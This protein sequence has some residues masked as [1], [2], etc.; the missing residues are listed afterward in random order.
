[1]NIPK[2]VFIDHE[3]ARYLFDNKWFPFGLIATFCL[4]YIN[5]LSDFST[6]KTFMKNQK[7]HYGFS[8]V[9]SK[10]G[11]DFSDQEIKEKFELEHKAYEYFKPCISDN[12]VSP[13]NIKLWYL[14]VLRVELEKNYPGELSDQEQEW[15]EQE[16][17][18]TENNYKDISD[19]KALVSGLVNHAFEQP[20]V[21][22]NNEYI[23]VE[24]QVTSNLTYLFYDDLYRLLY[25]HK[26]IKPQS[27]INCNSLFPAKNSKE[28][29]CLCCRNDIYK[30]NYSKVK[31][32]PAKRLH[33]NIL[34]YYNVVIHEKGTSETV[35]KFRNESNYYSAIVQG[36]KPKTRKL[37]NY[38][39]IK[40]ESEY[41]SWLENFYQE[42]K[43]N[44]TN[45]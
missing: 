6:Y 25:N 32:N 40:T 19:F 41:I 10:S 44:H 37:K 17:L 8:L 11:T 14:F 1:M 13:E 23:L 20:L 33:K 15:K 18:E 26:A 39:N 5:S 30:I 42:L 29:Y 9:D 21:N 24:H 4:N 34:N 43:Q 3:N 2:D 12:M 28:K 27:C 45:R 36:K 35:T 31:S 16:W 7:Q 22:D 38:Q